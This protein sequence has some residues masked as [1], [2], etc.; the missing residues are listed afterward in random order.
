ML[1]DLLELTLTHSVAVEE[2]GLD[3]WMV[4]SDKGT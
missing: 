4:V 1:D 2:D 3:E